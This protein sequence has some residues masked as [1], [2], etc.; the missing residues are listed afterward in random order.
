MMCCVKK[1]IKERKIKIKREEERGKRTQMCFKI[2]KEQENIS[3]IKSYNK[4]S[5]RRMEN[6][7]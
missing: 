4:T 6:N 5:R 1:R 7:K 2:F 3:T